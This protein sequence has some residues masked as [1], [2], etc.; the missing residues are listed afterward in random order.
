L[1]R[2]LPGL[3][4]I[5][6][7]WLAGPGRGPAGALV[8]LAAAGEDLAGTFPGQLAN[9]LPSMMPVAMISG[10]VPLVAALGGDPCGIGLVGAEQDEASRLGTGIFRART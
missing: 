8:V 5:V 9:S 2:L 10:A 1:R 6:S 3:F 7:R 4:G